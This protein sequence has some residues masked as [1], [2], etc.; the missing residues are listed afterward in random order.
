MAEA[1]EQIGIATAA[2]YPSLTLDAAV[3]L[4]GNTNANPFNWASRIRAVG[5]QMS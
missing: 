5:P 4:Q 3:G 2:Y 1:N